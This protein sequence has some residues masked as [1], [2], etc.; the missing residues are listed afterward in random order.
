[1]SESTYKQKL[2]ICGMLRG[3]FDATCFETTTKA[4]KQLMITKN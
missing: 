3:L 2:S 1:M 4:V